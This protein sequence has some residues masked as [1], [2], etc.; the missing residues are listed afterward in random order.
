[1]KKLIAHL[2]NNQVKRSY[3]KIPSDRNLSW[4]GPSGCGKTTILVERFLSRHIKNSINIFVGN[5]SVE[6]RE[7]IK[8]FEDNGSEEVMYINETVIPK[9][10]KFSESIIEHN[11]KLGACHFFINIADNNQTKTKTILDLIN[12]IIVGTDNNISVYLDEGEALIND[13]NIKKLLRCRAVKTECTLQIFDNYLSNE[14]MNNFFD[15]ARFYSAKVG[16]LN[17]LNIKNNKLKLGEIA[18]SDR[19]GV[20]PS[21]EEIFRYQTN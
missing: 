9:S 19:F 6:I 2:T 13:P 5:I 8:V 10:I 16:A 14:Y 21:V 20:A 17:N 4:I 7:Q 1:L 18:V 12:N 3:K 11:L 15:Y